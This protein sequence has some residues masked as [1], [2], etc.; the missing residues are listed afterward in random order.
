M[1]GDAKRRFC[2][3]CQLHVHNLSAMLPGE[4]T[5]FVAETRGPACITCELRADGTMVTRSH[6]DWVLRPPR[7]VAALLAA[8]LPGEVMPVK[9][10]AKLQ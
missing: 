2:Q 7:T 4:R 3:H 8:M 10:P 9:N 1:S 5:Q 6:W